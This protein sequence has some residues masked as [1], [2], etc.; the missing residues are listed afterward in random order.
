MKN[1]TDNKNQ[2]LAKIVLINGY[3][4]HAFIV[5]ALLPSKL[6]KVDEYIMVAVVWRLVKRFQ[7]VMS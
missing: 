3:G 2:A 6:S 1:N 5:R 4:Q 7:S